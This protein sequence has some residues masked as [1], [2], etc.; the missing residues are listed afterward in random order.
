MDVP[1]SAPRA[2]EEGKYPPDKEVMMLILHGQENGH[3]CPYDKQPCIGFD[4]MHYRRKLNRKIGK[5]FFY[6]GS[7]GREDLIPKWWIADN[8]RDVRDALAKQGSPCVDGE[9]IPDLMADDPNDIN[10]QIVASILKQI[11]AN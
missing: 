4:C 10:V 9:E 11:A 2:R 1:L 5:Y 8:A 7:G 3:S 6:C